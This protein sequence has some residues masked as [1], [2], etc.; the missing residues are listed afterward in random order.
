MDSNAWLKKFKLRYTG[1]R[2]AILNF[3]LHCGHALS[4]A[5]L[6]Q[7]L[8][9]KFDRV[10]IYRTLKVFFE[11][12]LIHKVLDDEGVNKYALCLECDPSQEEH[13]HDHIHFKCLQCGQ[14]LCLETGIPLIK[15]PKGFQVR[16]VNFLVQGICGQCSNG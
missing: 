6:E 7:G 5:D 12:G 2:G 4:H 14:T 8:Y 15:L 16:E 11:K 3:F 10:T 1:P 13:Q 9:E